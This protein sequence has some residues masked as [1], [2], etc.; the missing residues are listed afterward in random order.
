MACLGGVEHAA[1]VLLGL[2]DPLRD[3]LAEIDLVELEVE[4][5][6]DQAG[7][8]RLAGA[9]RARE[10][11]RYAGAARDLPRKPQLLEHLV[12]VAHAADQRAR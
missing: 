12:R 1:E 11:R 2:A 10:Q 5:A 9:G 8:H 3:D 4:L 6:R 7:D